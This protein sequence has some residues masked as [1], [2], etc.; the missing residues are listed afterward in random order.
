MELQPTPPRQGR[1]ELGGLCSDAVAQHKSAS[2]LKSVHRLCWK[3]CNLCTCVQVSPPH[4]VPHDFGQF[5]LCLSVLP[6][7]KMIITILTS[8]SELLWKTK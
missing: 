2:S 6:S 1:G 4:L 5:I 3:K 7:E 8:N